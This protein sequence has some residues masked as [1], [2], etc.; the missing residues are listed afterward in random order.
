[1]KK[2]PVNPNDKL[3][4]LITLRHW[5]VNKPVGDDSSHAGH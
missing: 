2:R 4:K 3:L 1:M 5:L